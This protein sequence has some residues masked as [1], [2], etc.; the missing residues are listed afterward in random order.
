MFELL[1][2]K[3]PFYKSTK[4]SLFDCIKNSYDLEVPPHVSTIAIDLMGRLLNK[5]PEKRLGVKDINDLKRHPYFAEIDW[6]GLEMSQTPENGILQFDK[7]KNEIPEDEN[8]TPEELIMQ[9]FKDKV[10][11]YDEDYQE[12]EDYIPMGN[13]YSSKLNLIFRFI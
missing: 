13:I 8:L 6:N 4:E 7:L 5:I 2:G 3:P 10:D 1:T 11:F 9:K 12:N